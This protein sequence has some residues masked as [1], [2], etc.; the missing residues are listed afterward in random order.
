MSKFKKIQ[1]ALLFLILMTILIGLYYE[2]LHSK[3]LMV[4][5]YVLKEVVAEQQKEIVKHPCEKKKEHETFHLNHSVFG[6]KT[7]SSCYTDLNEILSEVAI[8]KTVLYTLGNS[9]Y[10]DILQSFI[11]GVVRVGISNFIIVCLDAE[12]VPFVEALGVP[13]YIRPE[14][15]VATERTTNFVK[16]GDPKYVKFMQSKPWYS[17]QIAKAG[18]DHV[19]ADADVAI[20]L[21]VFDWINVHARNT[22]INFWI[23]DAG[24]FGCA[25]F[26][27]ALSCDPVIEILRVLTLNP[28]D[29][30]QTE[31]DR[32]TPLHTKVKRSYF[33]RDVFPDGLAMYRD[34]LPQK[35]GLTPYIVHPNWIVGKEIKILRL[36]QWG[37]WYAEPEVYYG[38][39]CQKFIMAE[40][41]FHGQNEEA[42]GNAYRNLFMMG[43][44]L[45]RSVIF[46]EFMDGP[47]W[48]DQPPVWP[49]HL[50]DLENVGRVRQFVD[51]RMSSFLKD[52]KFL[53]YTGNRHISI[54]IENSNEKK[55]ILSNYTILHSHSPCGLN[56]AQVLQSFRQ[57]EDIPLLIIADATRGFAGLS[58]IANEQ[59][60]RAASYIG[61][62]LFAASPILSNECCWWKKMD[63]RKS[64]K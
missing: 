10:T 25:G 35:A 43:Y 61:N 31:L 23:Q 9:G 3:E 19:Y 6:K 16:F 40:S 38:A 17:W 63:F 20:V 5:G 49:I 44:L 54:H 2:R 60:H 30:E 37:H 4:G 12:V 50:A 45:N 58:T 52:D 59:D 18:Y 42:L 56:S 21:N 57:Y 62:Q 8:N 39:N 27:F 22:D 14:L 64:E 29:N 41:L 13:C 11:A 55:K 48:V 47:N 26:F 28:T 33:P 24:G 53:H 1:S 36:R 51:F 34:H 32:L 15:I 7:Y 46:R